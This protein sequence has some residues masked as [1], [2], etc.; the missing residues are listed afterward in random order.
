MKKRF[1][2]IIIALVMCLAIIPVEAFAAIDTPVIGTVEPRFEAINT[3]YAL[4]KIDEGNG[5]ATC[6]GEVRAKK[7]VPVEVVVQ[8]QRLEGSTWNT[9]YTW[10]NTGTLFA[11]KSG[12]YAV[13][14]GYT[15][16][17][18]VTAFVYDTDGN[19]IESGSATHQV[20]YPKT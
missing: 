7:M 15:Y 10:S 6:V 8:L 19:I 14:K 9:L 12:N 11:S 13:A 17:T 5:I 1:C 18:R 16:R 20:S 3:I 2:S 4:L